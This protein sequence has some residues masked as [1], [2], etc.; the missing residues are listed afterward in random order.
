ML[1]KTL[2]NGNNEAWFERFCQKYNRLP[3]NWTTDPVHAL[4][5]AYERAKEFGSA[6]LVLVLPDAEIDGVHFKESETNTGG[7]WFTCI[8]S[9]GLFKTTEDRD[10]KLRVYTEREL[11]KFLDEHIPADKEGNEKRLEYLLK[12]LGRK[13]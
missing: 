11:A 13:Q 2:Y 12:R 6:M 8:T 4:E 10:R 7:K 3:R 5:Y 1:T 9:C